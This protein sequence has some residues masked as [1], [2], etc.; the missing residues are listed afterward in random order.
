MG[1]T[2]ETSH[3]GSAEEQQEYLNRNHHIDG[4]VFGKLRQKMKDSSLHD[5]KVIFA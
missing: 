2:G 4:G 1:L 3:V 5:L